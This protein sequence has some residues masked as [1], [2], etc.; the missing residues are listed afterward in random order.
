MENLIEAIAIVTISTLLVGVLFFVVWFICFVS[1]TKRTQRRVASIMDRL[2][3]EE[4]QD[5]PVAN[6][7]EI[8]K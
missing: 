4:K 5:E 2:G 8:K 1:D 6:L 3:L 7:T